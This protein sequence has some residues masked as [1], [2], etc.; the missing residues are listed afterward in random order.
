VLKQRKGVDAIFRII[1]NEIPALDKLGFPDVVKQLTHHHQGLVLVTGPSGCGKSTTLASMIDY[2]NSERKLHIITVEDPIEYVH[3]NKMANVTQ[4]EVKS[5]TESFASALKASLREDPDVILIGEMRDHETISMAITAAET[6]HLVLGTLHTR[7]AH[8]TVDRIIDAFPPQ[9]Q[10]QIRAMVSESLRGVVSQQLIPRADGNGRV[11]AYEVL[12]GGLAIAN[13]IREGKTFQIPSLMQIG[14]K[15]GMMLM[16][17]CLAKLLA[18][19]AITYEQAFMRAEN[20]KLI[21]KQ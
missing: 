5:H 14:V 19:K 16:D 11:L 10:N 12:V 1:K 7:N 3:P 4:R 18:A 8:K 21:P 17:Q 2:I 6:G 15:E 13:L 9:Q 20:K